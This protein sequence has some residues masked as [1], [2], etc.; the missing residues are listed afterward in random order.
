ME[1]EGCYVL[2]CF[3]FYFLN[4]LFEPFFQGEPL[5]DIMY[6]L[7]YYVYGKGVQIYVFFVADMILYL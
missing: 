3:F 1:K 2:F 7:C 5:Q 4:H 6:K